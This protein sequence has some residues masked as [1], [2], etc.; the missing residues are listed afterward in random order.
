MTDSKLA[1][2]TVAATPADFVTILEC[3]PG[4]RC[5]KLYDGGTTIA[6]RHDYD[7]GTYFRPSERAVSGLDD[8]YALYEELRRDATKMVI[9]GRLLPGAELTPSDSPVGP[10]YTYRASLVNAKGDPAT[11]E[12]VP[13]RWAWLDIDASKIAFD[14]SKRR[15]CV[16]AWRDTLP[17]GLRN[18]A[19]IVQFSASQHLS[20]TLKVHVLIWLAG[21]LQPD[22]VL[23]A[24]AKRRQFDWHVFQAVHPHYFADP[25]FVDCVDPLSP[26]ELLCFDGADAALDIADE[27][28]AAASTASAA[29]DGSVEID[30]IDPPS[31]DPIYEQAR[32]EIYKLL[33]P[34]DANC[35]DL[36]S[37]VAGI[38][39]KPAHS[40]P[41]REA[42]QLLR[43]LSQIKYQDVDVSGRIRFAMNAYQLE[44]KERASGFDG[45]K[46]L[47]G[48][49]AVAKSVAD[50]IQH[51][52]LTG[53][54]LAS[55]AEGRKARDKPRAPLVMLSAADRPAIVAIAGSD[56]EPDP[57]DAFGPAVDPTV[58]LE[59]LRFFCRDYDIAVGKITMLSGFAGGG[60]SM[61]ALQLG[62]CMAAGIPFLGA[63]VEQRPMIYFPFEGQHLSQD[64]WVRMCRA[65]GV[66]RAKI[67]FAVRPM[68]G[69][70]S[71]EF[72]NALQ[73]HMKRKYGETG[74]APGVI[75]DTLTSGM[76]GGAE[77][78]S[79]EYSAP[80]FD[81]GSLAEAYGT[82]VLVA[83]HDNK[84]NNVDP[85]K[86]VS[87]H[88]SI[89][90]SCQTHI[91]IAHGVSNP[92]AFDLVCGRGP[93]GGF[94]PRKGEWQDV[95]DPAAR[96]PGARLLGTQWGLKGVLLAEDKPTS[97]PEESIAMRRGILAA[98]A[99]C[100]LYGGSQGHI[101]GQVVG[102]DN[103]VKAVLKEM[104]AKNEIV[105]EKRGNAHVY[106]LKG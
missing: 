40:W 64:R 76:R 83:A 96:S 87:G 59:P 16:Q 61:L 13:R 23:R 24:W 93:M 69:S 85:L 78:N 25:P 22:S 94:K 21:E 54:V 82:L 28:L 10:G 30:D 51:S 27:D 44:D 8:L 49:E 60:K 53:R 95:T 4:K 33:E 5:A 6:Q 12:S 101:C 81:L 2:E 52:S 19:M 39:V 55:V 11:F 29:R 3:L 18:A 84:S 100:G 102:R 9:R 71:P 70:Y 36:L 91:Q 65:L 32:R 56:D 15:E 1:S 57:L 42:L 92:K 77:Q 17:D 67:P 41:E 47:I 43:D 26:R 73:E 48:N 34:Y 99:K 90:S 31:D 86:G 97:V 75:I 68:L 72:Y 88:N 89:P 45:L 20:A 79:A 35:Q 98:L 66:D 37:Y 105:F 14:A 50:I 80:L 58:P 103:E 38:C 106:A 62:I 63:A 74:V 46:K 7:A 104:A